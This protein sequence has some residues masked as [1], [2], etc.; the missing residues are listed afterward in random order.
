MKRTVAGTVFLMVFISVLVSGA[1]IEVQVKNL[2][3]EKGQVIIGLYDAGEKFPETGRERKGLILDLSSAKPKGT[4]SSLPPGN[5]AVSLFHDVNGNGK[6]DK[7]FMGIPTEGYGFSKNAYNWYGGAPGFE[8]A[9]FE[10][11]EGEVISLDINVRSWP[12][13]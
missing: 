13:V 1:G 12:P 10:L 4:F 3:S 9:S 11:E 8:Q 6:L 7:N 5:Y 2:D